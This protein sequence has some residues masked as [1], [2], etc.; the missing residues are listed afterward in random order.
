MAIALPQDFKEFLKLLNDNGVE[1]LLVSC[2]R[3][4]SL[5]YCFTTLFRYFTAASSASSCP[6]LMPL[7]VGSTLMCGG[8]SSV[9]AQ[10]PE[11]SLNCGGLRC[12]C[13]GQRE[14]EHYWAEHRGFLGLFWRVLQRAIFHSLAGLQFDDVVRGFRFTA[15]LGAF[16]DNWLALGIGHAPGDDAAAHQPYVLSSELAA[17]RHCAKLERS[18]WRAE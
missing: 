18:G 10:Q 3:G 16:E 7:V 6:S 5:R 15:Q 2:R 11:Q 9:L 1:Y 12:D 17:R 14:Q 13:G 4:L 8:N